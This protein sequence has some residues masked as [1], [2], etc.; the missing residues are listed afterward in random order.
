MTKK[1]LQKNIQKQLTQLASHLKIIGNTIV[2][3]EDTNT[4]DYDYYADLLS[5]LERTKILLQ[6]EAGLL[7]NLQTWEDFHET[8]E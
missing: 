5:E 4:W 7:I 2:D 6:I 1:S 3:S 8:D